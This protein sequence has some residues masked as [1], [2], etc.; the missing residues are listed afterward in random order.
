MTQPLR[1]L[2]ADDEPPALK[3]LRDLFE[4]EP[5]FV[6]ARE[7]ADGEECVRALSRESFDLLLLDVQMPGCSGLDVVRTI[8]PGRLPPV[9]FVTAFDEHAVRAFELHALDY[10]LKP[11]DRERFQTMLARARREI[12]RSS[13]AH[14]RRL[15]RLLD[16]VGR[17]GPLVLSSRGRTVLVDPR[18]VEWV[19][20]ADN[21]LRLHGAGTE[22]LV[23]G[24]LGA[25]EE[26][27]APRGFLR[28]H[29]SL[30]VNERAVREVLPRKSGELTLVLA[31]GA[32]LVSG[33]SY[34]RAI[35]A[36]LRGIADR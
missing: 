24:T 8:G 28:V 14:A 35:Q 21:Y 34:R 17:E 16:E 29:R 18:E 9:V 1:V 20:A 33:R 26:L 10:L 5:D 12:G 22:R 2:L 27:L 25:M 15:M 36:R 13:D 32:R 19:A 23:R 11:F 30:L 6:V 7:C 31:S 4:R 3:K